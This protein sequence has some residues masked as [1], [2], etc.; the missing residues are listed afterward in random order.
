ML[1]LTH[2]V[3]L[4]RCFVAHW[5]VRAREARH[6]QQLRSPLAS[7]SVRYAAAHF[8]LAFVLAATALVSGALVLEI[9]ERVAA[10]AAAKG[11]PEKPLGRPERASRLA[12]A[13]LLVLAAASFAR[14]LTHVAL[15][16]VR[17][18]SRYVGQ[19]APLPLELTQEGWDAKR[20]PASLAPWY[21]GVL[22]DGENDQPN[23]EASYKHQP[24]YDEA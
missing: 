4:A 6:Q 20:A 7:K 18:Y 10:A 14:A 2:V 8:T 5:A 12:C 13:L 24:N 22:D 9:G 3:L 16:L 21:L 1:C 17:Y 19:T 23:A 15:A 11:Q